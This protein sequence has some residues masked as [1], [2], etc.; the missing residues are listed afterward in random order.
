MTAGP[1]ADVLAAI[2]GAI[3]GLLLIILVWIV[4]HHSRPQ[5]KVDVGVRGWIHLTRPQEL[6]HGAEQDQEA[7]GETEHRDTTGN[8]RPDAGAVGP[9]DH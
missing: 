7:S 2:I 5:L 3:T 6:P 4:I 9:L 8:D 1:T